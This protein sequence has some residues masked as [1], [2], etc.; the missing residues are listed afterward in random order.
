VKQTPIL[1]LTVPNATLRDVMKAAL[2]HGAS[3]RFRSLGWS[4]S[5]F[6]R[7]GDL[8]VVSPMQGKKLAVGQVVALIQTDS[9]QMLIHRIIHLDASY[10]WIKGD[11]TPGRDDG[12]VPVE[13]IIGWV[14]QVKRNGQKV[15]FGQGLTGYWIA[16]LS[17]CDLLVPIMSVL[18]IVIKR[19]IAPSQ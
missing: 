12:I 18:R 10:C 5:P 8:V 9:D 13:N 17:R 4:M 6:I 2:E 16:L 15:W 1:D 14:I 7:E 3:F 11:N 19:T